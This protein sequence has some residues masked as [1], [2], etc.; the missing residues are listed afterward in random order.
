MMKKICLAIFLTLSVFVSNAEVYKS[1]DQNGNVTFSDIQAKGAKEVKVRETITYQ[2]PVLDREIAGNS[3]IEDASPSTEAVVKDNPNFRYKTLKITSPI[4]G[5]TLFRNLGT[6]NVEVEY[7]LEPLLQEG[8]ALVLLMNGEKQESFSFQDMFRG[9]YSF[10]L[11]IV[12]ETGR[13]RAE[14]NVVKIRVHQPTV[15]RPVQ[16]PFTVN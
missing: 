8:H 2:S 7:T 4:D 16:R 6:N 13:I 3:V 1:V 14:S 9:E 11:E 10:Q 15:P 12:D 5:E